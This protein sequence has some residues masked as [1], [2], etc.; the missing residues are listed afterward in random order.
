MDNDGYVSVLDVA[1]TAAD[2]AGIHLADEADG[3]GIS[4]ATAELER[5]ECASI[6]RLYGGDNGRS[7][8]RG[9]GATGSCVIMPTGFPVSRILCRL[10]LRGVF[11]P[12]AT[13]MLGDMER[14]SP[15]LT[16]SSPGRRRDCWLTSNPI[17]RIGAACGRRG[18]AHG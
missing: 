11:T 9:A 15:I 14:S 12:V 16:H 6:A 5:Y 3:W 18:G 4:Q 8:A 2:N 13:P 10:G 17:T 7:R 1:R